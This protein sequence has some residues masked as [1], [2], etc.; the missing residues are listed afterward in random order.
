MGLIQL[1]FF[2]LQ[3]VILVDQQLTKYHL[4]ELPNFEVKFF[5][6]NHLLTS[7]LKKKF[8]SLIY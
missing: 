3:L 6:S 5:S 7:W 1:F 4:T 2:S 8:S